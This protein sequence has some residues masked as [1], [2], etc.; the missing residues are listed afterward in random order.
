VR[1]KETELIRFWQTVECWRIF[2][3]AKIDKTTRCPILSEKSKKTPNLKK[4][5]K[6]I[7]PSLW[8]RSPLGWESKDQNRI[9]LA[10]APR[11]FCRKIKKIFFENEKN[12]SSISLS[13]YFRPGFWNLTFKAVPYPNVDS[14]HMSPR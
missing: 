5:T 9:W 11:F 13:L 7:F 4:M 12:V 10:Q 14:S 6:S 8:R 2:V 3:Q 1:A